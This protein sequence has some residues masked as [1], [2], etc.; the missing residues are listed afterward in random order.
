MILRGPLPGDVETI[1]KDAA[2]AWVR[3]LIASGFDSAP[4]LE[5]PFTTVAETDGRPIAIGGFIERGDNAIAW[6]MVGN[7][8]RPL[9]VPLC[10]AF[11]RVME[12][13]P[14]QI[15]EA[16]C[17]AGFAQSH[18][19]VKC[20]GFTLASGPRC[21]VPDGREFFKFVFRNSHGN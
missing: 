1:G 15:I 3:N 11:R 14:F 21:F 9:F 16:H 6:S 17:M 7:V 4:M 8:P 20:L 18:R 5:R 2:E 10:R 12:S 13:T 19:W